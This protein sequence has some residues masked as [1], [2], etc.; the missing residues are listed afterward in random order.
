MGQELKFS[1]SLNM[2][3]NLWFR[4]HY[5]SHFTDEKAGLYATVNVGQLTK[6]QF[7]HDS[8]SCQDLTFGLC[9]G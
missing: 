2:Q 1:I 3:Y 6:T 5:L 9:D 7:I 4:Y 8:K